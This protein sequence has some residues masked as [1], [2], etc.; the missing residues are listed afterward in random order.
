MWLHLSFIENNKVHFKPHGS[1]KPLICHINRG[2]SQSSSPMKRNYVYLLLPSLLFTFLNF[3]AFS[4]QSLGDSYKK[5][6]PFDLEQDTI[7]KKK[8]K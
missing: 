5:K 7:K 8:N 2:F 6:N 4:W 1:P 3:P